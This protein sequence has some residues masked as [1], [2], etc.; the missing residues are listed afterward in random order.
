MK[1]YGVR[2]IM[3]AGIFFNVVMLIVAG[4]FPYIWVIAIS[5]AV[6]GK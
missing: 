3:T 1:K 4:M 6:A 5:F 2:P